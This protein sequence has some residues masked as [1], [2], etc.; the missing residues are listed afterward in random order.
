MKVVFFEDWETPEQRLKGATD[1]LR[2][3]VTLAERAKAA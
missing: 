2:R 1:I 3:L